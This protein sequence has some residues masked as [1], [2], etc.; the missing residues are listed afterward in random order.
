MRWGL[1]GGRCCPWSPGTSAPPWRWGRPGGRPAGWGPA[2]CPPANT[3]TPRAFCSQHLAVV[4]CCWSSPESP[5][6]LLSLS[7]SLLLLLLAAARAALHWA[8]WG[9]SFMYIVHSRMSWGCLLHWTLYTV[10]HYTLHSSVYLHWTLFTVEHCTVSAVQC[11]AVYC[12]VYS[13][14]VQY[15]LLPPNINVTHK[16]TRKVLYICSIYKRSWDTERHPVNNFCGHIGTLS[17]PPW[18]HP[19]SLGH[20]Q[21]TFSSQ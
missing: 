3:V 15:L 2:A 12:T 16:Q 21:G 14:S 20:P 1:G 7:L 11:S 6:W 17:Q 5:P 8:S 4:D 10:E 13:T 18:P 19:R 9:G